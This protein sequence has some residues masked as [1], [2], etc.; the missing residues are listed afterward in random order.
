MEVFGAIDL[1]TVETRLRIDRRRNPW[2][3]KLVINR[4]RPKNVSL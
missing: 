3:S 2:D 4:V 1:L